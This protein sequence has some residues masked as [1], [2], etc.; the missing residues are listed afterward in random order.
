MT[1]KTPQEKTASER[2]A[3]LLST[4]LEKAKENGGIWLN[5]TGKKAPSIYQKTVH[6]SPF[7]ALILGLHS[8]QN[9][10]K[11][12]LYTLFSDA[13]KEGAS[14]QS[15]EKGVPFLWYNW[16]EYQ[17]KN[18][19]EEKISRSDYQTLP[20]EKQSEYKG[21]RSREIRSLFNLEQTTLPMVNKEAFEQAVSEKG[22]LGDRS[23]VEAASGSIR[24]ELNNLIRNVSKNMV[25]VRT[26]TTGVSHYDPKEDTIYL[27][28]PDNYETTNAYA[29]AAIE[30][31]VMATGNSGRL[32]REG[33]VMRGGKAPDED[34][35]KQERLVVELAKAV[36]LQE[37]GIP[38]KLSE[39]TLA[40][41]DFWQRELKENPCLM[42]ILERDVNNAVDMI[43]KAER[44]ERIELRT[45]RMNGTNN[46]KTLL[47]RH[48]YVA[49]EIRTLPNREN[50]EMVIVKDA[51]NKT[52]DVVLPAGAS[53]AVD[54]EIPGMNKSRIEHALQKEGFNEIHFFNTDGALGFR[55]DD[56]YFDG[57]EISVSRLSN[58]SLEEIT[59][60]DVADAVKRS[61]MVD[62]DKILML[63][64]DD[65]RWALYMKPEN[66]N[67]FCVYPEKEDVNRY[68]VAM[69][70]GNA[71]TAE[72][73]RQEMATRYYVAASDKPDMKV[74]LFRSQATPEELA[75]IE[76][77]T[78]FKTK[79]TEKD[80]S[81]ILCMP[82]VEGEKLKPREVS[83]QQW[84]RMWLADDMQE[85]K[86]HLAATL[87]ADVLRPEV[88]AK[89]EVNEQVEAKA[90]TDKKQSTTK[91]L[92]PMM[93]QYL[94]LKS[95]HPDAL[96][97]FRSGDFYQ[98]YM[99]DAEKASKIL[100]ITLTRSSK[101][102]DNQGK[103]LSMAGFPYHALDS[104]LPKLIRAGQ[105]VAICDMI[106]TPKQKDKEPTPS[107]ENQPKEDQPFT[108]G[109][110][111]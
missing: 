74:D 45:E 69:K 37:L 79:E 97:L 61:G 106:E 28:E 58:W 75:K 9:G 15:K 5:L 100:G 103:P 30:Q 67:A 32:A 11:T 1:D 98:T 19:P 36:K 35:M 54:N 60:L 63:R 12:N 93:K 96:L 94:D 48:Y 108:R 10:Y 77:V 90:E 91:E 41:A 111:H 2:Q 52:A 18:N 68:F 64:S 73:T 13:K 42:D 47:P 92:S 29:R 57:K 14:V 62:F 20:T 6:I 53:D 72:Q 43:H 70:Q 107:V 34:A 104:F 56:S 40:M 38:A 87:F 110:H 84:Q 3:E 33:M 27:A 46:V 25:E 21:I 7:N 101:T 88:E 99:E 4:A 59:R 78:I 65:G 102:L 31:I 55:K 50:K 86:R 71:E 16:N 17:N 109:M 44:G 80:P 8:D 81:R 82:T 49:D 23:N 26:D 22:R 83:Q 24:T 39:D 85:Y 105:R 66:E 95:K 51:A 76:H 89:N